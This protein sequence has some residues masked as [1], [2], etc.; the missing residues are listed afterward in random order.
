MTIAYTKTINSM[1]AY[2]DI[3]GETNVVFSIMW[4]LVGEENGFSTSCPVT[5]NVPYTAG[6]PFTPY[7]QLTQA[8]VLAWID[9]YTPLAQMQ[10]FQNTVSFS[11][12]QQQQQEMPP[13]PWAPP[14]PT[15]PTP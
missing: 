11:L 2:K 14:A 1:Q 3:D 6:Q 5:T 10:A 4:N 9:E 15:P 12:Q 7:D 13:L 8:Q